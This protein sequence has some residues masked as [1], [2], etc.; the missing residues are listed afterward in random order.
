MGLYINGAKMGKP[1]I[2]GVKHNAYI[3]GQKIW[4]DSPIP[5]HP[6]IIVGQFMLYVEDGGSFGIPVSGVRGDDETFQSYTWTIDWGDGITTLSSSTGSATKK[7]NHT[8]TDGKAGHYIIIKGSG[9]NWFKAFGSHLDQDRDNLAKIKKILS[10]ITTSMR[11]MGPYSYSRMFYRCTGLTS[12]PANLLQ[13]TTL[14]NN[15]YRA[16]FT[17]CAG[18]TSIPAN[19]LPETLIADCCIN[20]FS[21]CIGL[22]DIGTIDSAWFNRN[23]S[24]SQTSMFAKCTAI[25]TPITY[26]D[27]PTDWK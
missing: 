22:I 2:N 26:A 27:I 9:S 11:T 12:I 25:A 3:N 24:Y 10:P 5:P 7:I 15:C 8:Y 6:P 1:Y 23:K 17:Y 14:S 18:L 20:M 4:N 21:N 16:M 13:A 19:L